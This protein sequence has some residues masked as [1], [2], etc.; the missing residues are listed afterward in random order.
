[1][2]HHLPVADFLE[3]IR[4]RLLEPLVSSV[5]VPLGVGSAF[6]GVRDNVVA[7]LSLAPGAPGPR[8]DV[9]EGIDAEADRHCDAQDTIDQAALRVA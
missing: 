1:M 5:V 7:D 6:D 8:L 9:A 2:K 3:Q 4:E